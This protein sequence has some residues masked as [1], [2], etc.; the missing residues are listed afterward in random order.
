MSSD[1]LMTTMAKNWGAAENSQGG[2]SVMLA[3][4][5]PAWGKGWDDSEQK[6]LPGPAKSEEITTGSAFIHLVG[7]K[8]LAASPT[9]RVPLT[10]IK[11]HIPSVAESSEK[12][13]LNVAN[14][15]DRALGVHTV[16]KTPDEETLQARVAE[17][18]AGYRGLFPA[19][20]G[21]M[22]DDADLVRRVMSEAERKTNAAFRISLDRDTNPNE[23]E[24]VV[25]AQLEQMVGQYT[26]V[27]IREVLRDIVHAQAADE[28][29]VQTAAT[30]TRLCPDYNDRLNELLKQ[31]PREFYS[32]P[33]LTTEVL[34]PSW[35]QLDV[36]NTHWALTP[37]M[38]VARRVEVKGMRE[39]QRRISMGLVNGPNGNAVILNESTPPY[40]DVLRQKV[41]RWFEPVVNAL[42]STDL[43]GTIVLRQLQTERD[44]IY[45]AVP[46]PKAASRA[47]NRVAALYQGAQRLATFVN[48]TVMNVDNDL[49]FP[50]RPSVVRRMLPPLALDVDIKRNREG[51]VDLG[52]VRR[53]LRDEERH[54]EHILWE[55]GENKEYMRRVAESGGPTKL[56]KD[57][58]DKE[59]EIARA[60]AL[61]KSTGRLRAEA[62]GMR[63]ALKK[64]GDFPDKPDVVEGR[65]SAPIAGFQ[66]HVEKVRGM[67]KQVDDFVA[68]ADRETIR[69]VGGEMCPSCGAPNFDGGACE[70]CNVGRNVW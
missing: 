51:A 1:E 14:K 69:R 40:V 49:R 12:V 56:K 28:S 30:F 48:G 46:D 62:E 3:P 43:G 53:R 59:V 27:E 31:N 5:S 32:A 65:W 24:K 18:E 61:G 16:L 36:E 63:I 70:H 9:I 47:I 17:I 45:L 68:T 15:V 44:P 64:I 55:M 13:I 50:I 10:N 4:V 19:R 8:L 37:G 33:W 57:L 58:R 22:T 29:R 23:S 41:G 66:R 38:L 20:L 54:Y 2:R 35:M 42:A 7:A 6:A 25:A 60:A 34:L 21:G 26:A 67:K 39:D 11:W 52:D